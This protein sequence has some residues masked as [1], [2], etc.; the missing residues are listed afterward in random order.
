MA[1]V[2]ICD[3]VAEDALEQALPYQEQRDE[4]GSGQGE[5]H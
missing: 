1:R 4:H 3:A 2:L 5:S